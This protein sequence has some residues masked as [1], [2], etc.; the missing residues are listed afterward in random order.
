LFT[1]KRREEREEMRQRKREAR[2]LSNIQEPEGYSSDEKET[3]AERANFESI[4]R[5]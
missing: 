3:L 2:K 4:K 5:K 1:G